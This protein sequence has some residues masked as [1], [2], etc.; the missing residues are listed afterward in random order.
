MTK[1]VGILN[2]TPDSFSDGGEFFSPNEAISRAKKMVAEGASVIDI[3]AE[4]TRP[5]A[6]LLSHE[7]EWKRLKEIIPAI[8]RELPDITLSLDTRHV[9]TIEKSL[10]YGINWVND[11]SGFSDPK[12]LSLFQS[13]KNLKLVLMHSMGVPADPKIT[14]NSDPMREVLEWTQKKLEWLKENY[15]D[16]ERII[17]DP[18][19]GFGKTKEQSLELIKN[20]GKFNE[21]KTKIM[22]GHSRK[23]FLTLFT[24]KPAENRDTETL[25]VTAYLALLNIDYLRVHNVAKN[26]QVVKV[27]QGLTS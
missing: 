9:E 3:G 24:N 10:E 1:L 2:I 26:M 23:S 16:R 20:M 25:A 6:K 15:I 18:G 22:V 13:H 21:F 7:E 12:M 8:R 14:I 4:S 17:F 19:I 27:M 5:G 11:V